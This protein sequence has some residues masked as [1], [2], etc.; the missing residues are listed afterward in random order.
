MGGTAILA[1]IAAAR[2]KRDES[3]NGRQTEGWFNCHVNLRAQKLRVGGKGR[4][5]GSTAERQ[6][7]WHPFQGVSH[8]FYRPSKP[9]KPQNPCK[10]AHSR[11]WDFCRY[12]QCR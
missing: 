12:P 11:I 3:S 4:K 9:K 7:S 5:F 10:S 8:C 6:Y 2:T 1:P